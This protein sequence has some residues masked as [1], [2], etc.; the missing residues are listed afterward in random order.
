LKSLSTGKCAKLGP[1][2]CR[3]FTV[4]RCIRSSAYHLNLPP[5]VD[6]HPVFHVSHLKELLGFNDNM[7][8]SKDLVIYEDLAS[9]PY[10]PEK[11]LDSRT[12]I[13]RS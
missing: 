2:Y 6:I 10:S 1:C 9:K 7:V 4:L 3:P 11:I 12:K 5:G 8:T 13:L